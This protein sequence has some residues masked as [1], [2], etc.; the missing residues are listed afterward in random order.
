MGGLYEKLNPQLFLN[1][2]KESWCKVS[3]DDFKGWV[4]NEN[5]WGLF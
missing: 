5:L 3:S 4:K 1:K 2:C